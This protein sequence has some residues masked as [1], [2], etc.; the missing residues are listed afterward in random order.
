MPSRRSFRAALLAPVAAVALAGCGGAPAPAAPALAPPTSTTAACTNLRA[1]DQVPTPDSGPGQEPAPADVT[2]FATKMAPLI[3]AA[4]AGAPADLAPTLDKLATLI[5]E[6]RTSGKM[7]SFED[8]AVVGAINDSE[9]WAHANCGFQNVDLTTAGQR[10]DGV[11]ATLKAGTTSFAMT[12]K[13]APDAFVVALVVR[14]KDQTMTAA[15]LQ[16]MPAEQ[17]FGAVDAAPAAAAA[18][19]GHHQRR[20]RGAHPGTLVPDQPGRS[21]R[22]GRRPTRTGCSRSSPFPDV[23]RGR[24]PRRCARPAACPTCRAA[25]ARR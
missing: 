2:A 23:R 14:P 8:P 9:A 10:F 19:G 3:D 1:V 18:A 25:R 21:P 12:N 24:A 5:S 11:P 13:G 16:A 7:P 17:L 22:A 15:A 6:A 20:D 4:R